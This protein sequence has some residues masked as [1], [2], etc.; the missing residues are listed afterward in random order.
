MAWS[1]RARRLRA[2]FR[3]LAR[4]HTVTVRI[5]TNEV[6]KAVMV[7]PAP[8]KGVTSVCHVQCTPAAGGGLRFANRGS[9]SERCFCDFGDGDDR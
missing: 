8:R 6:R 5:K 1:V 3:G 4:A 7:T 2:M 9:L